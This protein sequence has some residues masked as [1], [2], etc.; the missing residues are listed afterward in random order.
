MNVLHVIP[1]ASAIYGGPVF[2]VKQMAEALAERGVSI[3]VVTTTAHGA[4]E[5]DVPI[6]A[7]LLRGAARYFY[8]PRQGPRFWMYSRPLRNWLYQHVTDYDLVHVHGLF[9]YPTLPA[10]AAARHFG[11][12]YIITPHGVLDPWSMSQKWWKKWP[13]FY[14]L[15]RRNL[16]CANVIHV[17]ASLEAS[18][19]ARLGFGQKTKIIPLSIDLPVYHEREAREGRALSLLFLSRLHPKKGL[20]VLF[21]ALALLR[22]HFNVMARLRVVGDGPDEYVAELTDLAKRLGVLEHIEFVG[23]LQGE[24]KAQALAEAD[25]FVLPSYQENFSLA[26]A[27]ALAV[28]TPVVVSDQVGIA[29]EIK[30]A[31][32]G[33]VVPAHA[34]KDLANAIA[35]FSNP[36]FRRTAGKNARALAENRFSPAQFGTALLDLYRDTL[37][38]K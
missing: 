20:P 33:L 3:D 37:E 12:P 31:G 25:V 5:L 6:G 18:G 22:G 13:Y 15:E 1:Y 4:E 32:A 9:A 17:T 19:V 21:E 36:A 23:F 35:K 27:E 34:P 16:A 2:V 38:S 11:I 28:G 26:A 29:E 8:F 24:A 14:F 10:C 30:L 7:P